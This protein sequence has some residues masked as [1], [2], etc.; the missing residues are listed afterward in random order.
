VKVG[1]KVDV[2]VNV[3]VGVGVEVDVNVVVEVSVGV[4]VGV[5]LAVTV[6]VGVGVSVMVAVGVKLGVGVKVEV[7]VEM[8]VKVSVE[9]GVGVSVGRSIIGMGCTKD[10]AI[11][12]VTFVSNRFTP[13]VSTFTRYSS[14]ASFHTTNSGVLGDQIILFVS[15]SPSWRNSPKP[16]NCCSSVS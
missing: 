13:L 8:G 3:T 15:L 4:N 6:F 11:T 2:G 16:I 10:H 12:F 14:P 9:V 7:S 1:V 5:A